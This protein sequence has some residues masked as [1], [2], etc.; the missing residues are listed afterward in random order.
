[1]QSYIGL[2]NR[3][4]LYRTGGEAVLC[5]AGKNRTG[6]E[7]SLMVI[8]YRTG[9]KGSLVSVLTGLQ[10]AGSLMVIL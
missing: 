6:A 9:A 8:L 10:A 3:A 1:M 5:R 7:G 4:V 2:A